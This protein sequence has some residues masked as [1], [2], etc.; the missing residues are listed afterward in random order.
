MQTSRAFGVLVAI[1]LRFVGIA[2]QRQLGSDRHRSPTIW[3]GSSADRR[4]RKR[5]CGSS[6]RPRIFRR[7]SRESS[8]RTTAAAILLPDLPKATYTVWVRGYG[9]VDSA[10]VQATPGKLVNLTAV[11]A[12]DARAAAQYYPA[13]YWFSLRQAARQE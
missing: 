3:P 11:A 1:A 12:P 2:A 5:A 13:G 6:R 10:K 4:D 8:S 7:A 9:L